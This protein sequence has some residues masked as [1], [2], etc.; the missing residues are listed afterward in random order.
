MIADSFVRQRD[1]DANRFRFFVRKRGEF[2]EKK[3][4]RL[5]KTLKKKI[6]QR[7]PK[8]AEEFELPWAA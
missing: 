4:R 5:S 8:L 7:F 6:L 3:P 2:L 1:D